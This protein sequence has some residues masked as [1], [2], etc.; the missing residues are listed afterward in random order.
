[1]YYPFMATL[2][3]VSSVASSAIQ[4]SE[5]SAVNDETTGFGVDDEGQVIY[6]YRTDSEERMRC[7]KLDGS[8][9]NM[10][11]ADYDTGRKMCFWKGIDGLLYGFL[12]TPEDSGNSSIWFIKIQEGEITKIRKVGNPA[13]RSSDD[14][15]LSAN[16]TFKVQ[17]RLIYCRKY[18][19][20]FNVSY[21]LIDIS[22]ESFYQELSTCQ[23]QPNM[24][25]NDR[26]CHFD[27]KTFSCTLINIDSGETSLLYEPDKL[28]LS[29]YDIDQ[30]M[31]VTENG[32]VFSAVQLS[33]GNYVVAK[34]GPD[35][36]VTIQQSIEGRLTVIVPL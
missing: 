26:L 34:I 36:S 7:R 24:V 28:Q 21:D 19:S 8:F 3:K 25:V 27:D 23:V 32:V 17:G 15:S 2:Y 1:M 30:I 9:V 6:T 29:N 13:I 11:I 4:F 18:S 10:I 22:G 35:N 31:S 14:F 12:Q 20:S 33:D 16:N 5:I